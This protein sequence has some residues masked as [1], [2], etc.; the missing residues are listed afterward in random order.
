MKLPF[1]SNSSTAFSSLTH[2]CPAE[3]NERANG[4]PSGSPSTLI[5]VRMKS[6]VLVNSCTR[7]LSSSPTHTFPAESTATPSGPWSWPL[8]APVLPHLRT[9]PPVEVNSSTRS[10]ELSAT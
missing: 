7:W 1:P 5:T 10:L 8:P 6:P 2:R 3:S 9:K 4:P